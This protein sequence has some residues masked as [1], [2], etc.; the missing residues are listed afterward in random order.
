MA[1]T[2]D[3][4]PQTADAPA[5]ARPDL[6]EL[7]RRCAELGPPT[8]P[9]EKAKWEAEQRARCRQLEEE[10]LKANAFQL[11]TMSYHLGR[12]GIILLLG[13]LTLF[14]GFTSYMLVAIWPADTT[15]VKADTGAAARLSDSLRAAQSSCGPV[16]ACQ[17]VIRVF[18]ADSSWLFGLGKQFPGILL[19]FRPPRAGRR[20]LLIALMAGG[21]GAFVS[22]ILSLA[23]YV[24]NR[25]LTRSWG[26]WY[27]AR[28]P[29][30]MALGLFTYLAL[31]AGLLNA[32]T[33]VDVVSPYGVAAISVIVG[34]FI[35][36][37]T[38]KLRDVAEV[39]FASSTNAERREAIHPAAQTP[40][41]GSTPGGGNQPPAAPAFPGG[42][43][44]PM[45]AEAIKAAHQ[46]DE[47]A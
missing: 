4:E 28:P 21:L 12:L 30:G 37:A 14:G 35:R 8:D 7:T 10:R 23:T 2:P 27:L 22:S 9:I 20:I 18:Q 47:G 45:T 6:D 17:D 15:T 29:A 31:R 41:Q 13:Y 16:S 3:K 36:Q 34:M 44:P 33:N 1:E 39:I 32:P 46:Q 42:A 43:A 40:S 24:G 19:D 26:I 38:D 11:H 25:E 5:G